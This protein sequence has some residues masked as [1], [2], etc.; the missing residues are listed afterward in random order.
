[1][2]GAE[3]RIWTGSAWVTAVP[4]VYRS[5]GTWQEVTVRYWSGSEWL[6]SVTDSFSDNFNRANQ[7]LHNSGTQWISDNIN[8]PRIISNTLGCSA[9]SAKWAYIGVNL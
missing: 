6:P 5:D 4:K 7:A 1:M 9:G 3:V 8:D 2:A